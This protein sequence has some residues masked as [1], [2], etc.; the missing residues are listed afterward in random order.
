MRAIAI[1]CFFLSGASSLVFQVIWTRLFSLVFGTTTLAISTVLTAFM[2]GL[3]LGAFAAGRIAD[4]IKSPLLAYAGA[5]TLI[6]LCALAIPLAAGPLRDLNSLAYAHYRDS[7]LA[8]NAIRFAA[9]WA[10]I[11]LPTTLMGATLPLLSRHFVR[12]GAEHRRVG[13][14]VGTLYAVNTAGA[15]MGT[16]G[17]G[18]VLLPQIGLRATNATAA[19]INLTLAVVVVAAL[20]LVRR[21][22]RHAKTRPRS[23]HDNC[24]AAS[25]PAS[26]TRATADHPPPS[27]ELRT[28]VLAAFFLSGATAMVYEVLWARALSLSFGSSVYSFSLVLSTFLIGLAAGAAVIGRLSQNSP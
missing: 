19:S 8:L 5:E 20:V 25:E 24:F 7:Q 17:A 3:A 18:F 11:I 6:G 10:V 2:T 15:V 12:D 26:S 13:A 16:L 14:R 23:R 9:S 22:R 27:R 21:R 28:I 4:R 1:G